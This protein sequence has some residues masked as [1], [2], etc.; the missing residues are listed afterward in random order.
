VSRTPLA[1]IARP[2]IT[3]QIVERITAFILGERLRPGD[4][5]PSER[6]LMARLG[7]G[8]SSLREAIKTLSA[9]GIVD[10]QIGDGM[11]VGSGQTAVLT[12]PLSW[13]LLIGEHNIREVIEARRAV[14]TELCALA[15]LRATPE[16]LNA[17]E[18]HFAAM[19]SGR[20]D[21][22]TFTRADQEFHL[23]IARAARNGVLYH[24]LDTLRH[25]VRVWI[26]KTFSEGGDHHAGFPEHSAIIAALRAHDPVA[27]REVMGRHLDAAGARLL[28]VLAAESD[29]FAAQEIDVAAGAR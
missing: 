26:Y 13:G 25:V 29:R 15:A 3:D 9:I 27:A 24:V 4:K 10:V 21:P 8:R 17:I 2:T 14:E 19:E 20:D 23:A 1:P 11:Y 7:V 16:D 5:L 12:K 28:A 18:E 6:E 22:E